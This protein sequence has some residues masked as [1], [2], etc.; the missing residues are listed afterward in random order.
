M[1]TNVHEDFF[2]ENCGA[3][4]SNRLV[5]RFIIHHSSFGKTIKS[6]KL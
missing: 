1:S 3:L 5:Q 4:I 6:E 2:W